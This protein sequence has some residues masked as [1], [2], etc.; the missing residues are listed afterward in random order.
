VTRFIRLSALLTTALVLAACSSEPTDSGDDA[1]GESGVGGKGSGGKSGGGSAGTS[2]LPESCP[3]GPGEKSETEPAKVG[4]V[5]ATF[6]DEQGD[7]TRAGLVQVC[8]KN[9]CIDAAVSANGKL[10]QTLDQSMDAP[11]CKFGDGKAWGKLAIPMG[12][13]DTALG[14]LTVVRLPDFTDGVA[15]TPGEAATS[16]GVTLSLSDDAVVEYDTLSYE[17]E[18]ML[19]FRA[20]PL[21]EAAL[22]QLQQGFVAGFALS[23]LETR[24]CP[25]PALSVEN[26]AEL[27]PG[28]ELE[29]YILGLDVGEMWAPYAR[30]QRVGEGSVSEDGATLEFPEG[31]PVLTAIGI[32]EKG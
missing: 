22:A 8:A 23:P 6:V 24:I 15:L 32:K 11:A 26:T 27:A 2:V 12:G 25:S 30:W 4:V 14:T 21:P 5:S 20:A 28:T 16:A 3:A 9:V 29:L 7:P 1:G 31:V 19:G 17:D 10:V 18:A 13:G